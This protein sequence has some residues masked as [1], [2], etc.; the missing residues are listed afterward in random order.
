MIVFSENHAVNL[1]LTARKSSKFPWENHNYA[2]MWVN[3][4]PL[5]FLIRHVPN[6]LIDNKFRRFA[7]EIS[8]FSYLIYGK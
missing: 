3:D 1:L 2:G 6:K 7:D 8:I 5:F 4:N